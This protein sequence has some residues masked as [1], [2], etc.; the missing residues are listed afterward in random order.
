[1]AV[2]HDGQQRDSLSRS[3]VTALPPTLSL[4][5]YLPFRLSPDCGADGAVGRCPGL[6]ALLFFLRDAVDG[7]ESSARAWRPGRDFQKYLK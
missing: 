1:M 2:L 4:S 3:P 5:S 6:L 7:N